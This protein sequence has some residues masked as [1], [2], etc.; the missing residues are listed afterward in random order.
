MF[1]KYVCTPVARGVPFTVSAAIPSAPRFSLNLNFIVYFR[2]SV[3]RR[4]IVTGLKSSFSS[5][6]VC[7]YDALLKK[8]MMNGLPD[9]ALTSKTRVVLR[10]EGN[11]TGT[12]GNEYFFLQRKLRVRMINYNFICIFETY[13]EFYYRKIKAHHFSGT[14]CC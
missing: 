4:I 2:R 11:D 14:V 5:Y 12:T 8:L 13:N 3:C 10:S 7:I 9:D 6:V 1:K